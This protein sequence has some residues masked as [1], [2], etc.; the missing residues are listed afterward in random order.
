M[1]CCYREMSGRVYTLDDARIELQTLAQEREILGKML[2][3]LNKTKEAR[4]SGQTRHIS[5]TAAALAAISAAT[6]SARR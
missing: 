2:E 3:Q 6:E 4:T 1:V 5:A